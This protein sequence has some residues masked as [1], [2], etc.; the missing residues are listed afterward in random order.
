[1]KAALYSGLAVAVLA[2]MPGTARADL[3]NATINT[4]I[5]LEGEDDNGFYTL[6]VFD[7]TI[8]VG[9]G[10]TNSYNF[11]RQG[12]YGGFSTQT[13]QL[14][15]TIGLSITGD[16]IAITFNGQAQ[17]AELLATFTSIPPTI[18]SATETD[19]GFLDG[20][21]LPLPNAFT[22]TSLTTEAF[23]L[24]FQPGTDTTQ[25]DLLTF[26]TVTP[27]VPEPS[28]MALMATGVLAAI[29]VVRRKF[30]V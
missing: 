8:N 2:L 14:T 3:I 16:T 29:G 1:M 19:S 20:V 6:T 22:D 4:N 11:F 18:T 7:G 26:E 15:G 23:Y 17:P 13:N 25:T 24:G 28:S 10:F 5:V 30:R 27:T 12:T 9:S 21:A